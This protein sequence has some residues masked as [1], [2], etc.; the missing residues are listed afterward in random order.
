MKVEAPGNEL[1]ADVEV[2]VTGDVLAL[3]LVTG[4]V[5]ALELVELDSAD[6]PSLPLNREN[7]AIEKMAITNARTINKVSFFVRLVKARDIRKYP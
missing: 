4:D 6:E 2:W 1:E 3:E 5:L 7:S